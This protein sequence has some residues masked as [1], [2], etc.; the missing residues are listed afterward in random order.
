MKNTLLV[1]AL[2]VNTLIFA[3]AHGEETFTLGED[4]IKQNIPCEELTDDQLELIGDY[5]MEQMHP[6]ELHERMDQ[7][8]GG[9]GSAQL[10]QAHINMARMF[11]CGEKG[12]MSSGMMNTMMNRGGGMMGMMNNFG[13]MGWGGGGYGGIVMLLYTLILIGIVVLLYLW[14]IKLWRE[15][16]RRR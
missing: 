7:M 4:V 14:I 1:L 16:A 3:V 12:A 10:R 15:T 8:M 2:L 11:Y 9:E 5:S 13:M 6:G